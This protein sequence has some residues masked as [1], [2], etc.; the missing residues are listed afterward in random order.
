MQRMHCSIRSNKIAL[1]AL[2]PMLVPVLLSM[3]SAHAANMYVCKDKDG[4]SLLTNISCKNANRSNNNFSSYTQTEKVTWYKETNVHTYKNWGSSESSVL[5][6]YSKNKDAYDSLIQAAAARHGVDHGLLKAMMHTESGFNPRARSPVGAQ[7]LMQLMPA[8]ARRFGVDDAWNP[9]QNI[10]GGAKYLSWLLRRFNNTEKAV[11]AYNA[12]E[13]NVDKYGGIPPF[14]ET[15]DY[16]K[17]VMSR[18]NNLYRGANA[19]SAS[20][21]STSSSSLERPITLAALTPSER[22]D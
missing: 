7:G 20:Q 6:S 11:A 12:G 14:R 22:T 10:D 18:Y 13:G 15:R 16:V 8:T 9:E 21:S 1:C 17:R 5:P 4:N 19:F 2:V 3:S